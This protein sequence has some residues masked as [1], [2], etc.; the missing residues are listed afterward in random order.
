MRASIRVT[1]PSSVRLDRAKGQDAQRPV[2][3]H[4]LPDPVR[5][6]AGLEATGASPARRPRKYRSG[7]F[8]KPFGRCN[9]SRKTATARQA[10]RPFDYTAAW[11]LAVKL[12]APTGDTRSSSK[13]QTFGR[14]RHRRIMAAANQRWIG[15]GIGSARRAVGIRP[16]RYPAH[17]PCRPTRPSSATVPDQP[18]RHRAVAADRASAAPGWPVARSRVASPSKAKRMSF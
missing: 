7:V 14:Y 10:R 11:P 15:N 8:E 12:R 3:Q 6:N 2:V 13:A 5:S 4:R 18:P 1:S 9:V 16:R 17:R